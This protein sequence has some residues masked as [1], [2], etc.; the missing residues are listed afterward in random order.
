MAEPSALLQAA[1]IDGLQAAQRSV[2]PQGGT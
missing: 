2:A 1:G